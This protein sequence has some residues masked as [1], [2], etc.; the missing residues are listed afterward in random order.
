MRIHTYR[1]THISFLYP[2]L[3]GITPGLPIQR[4]RGHC[5]GVRQIVEFENG[6]FGRG[7]KRGGVVCSPPVFL[8]SNENRDGKISQGFWPYFFFFLL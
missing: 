5:P 8:G 2:Q 7:I 1:K 3:P 6:S 4:Q